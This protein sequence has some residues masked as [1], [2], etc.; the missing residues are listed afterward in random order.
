MV[1][2]PCLHR[3]LRPRSVKKIV[4]PW[5][6]GS[7]QLVDRVNDDFPV[8]QQRNAMAD[9][10]Q[11]GEIVGHDDDGD[12][13][14]AIELADQRV[15][16][17]RCERVE[18]GRRLVEEENARVEG[19]RPRQ[20]CALD[21]ASRELRW[22]F[23]AGFGLKP[24][25]L[26][27]HAG[28]LFLRFSGQVGM[29]AQWQHYVLS[30]RQRRE[31]RTLLEEHS[32]ERGALCLS[33]RV[34]GL[35]VQKDLPTVR[36]PQTDQRFEQHGLAR[37]GA[38]GDAEYF[39]ACHV[40]AD[41]VVHLLLSEAIH[42]ATRGDNRCAVASGG[43]HRPSFSNRIENSASSTITRKIDL[44]TARVVSRPTLSAEPRTLRPCMQPTMPITMANTGALTSPTKRSRQST[45]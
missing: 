42:D 23:D 41:V 22:E 14:A 24:G 15:D 16:P 18:I 8:D 19:Q 26:E 37:S 32:D 13:E 3:A 5:M 29:L 45:A 4:N 21:H 36:V 27:L 17:A 7:H 40:E 20:R 11:C 35:T 6:V 1:L 39:P 10:E 43:F 33:K 30:D 34:D 2:L 44:T 31:E 9:G 25:K 12:P 38:P 28:D